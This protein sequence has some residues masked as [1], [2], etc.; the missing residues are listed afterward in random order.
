VIGGDKSIDPATF[1]RLSFP[2][3]EL[4]FLR[5]TKWDRVVPAVDRAFEQ[6]DAAKPQ[7]LVLD[8]RGNSGG[9]AT[10]MSPLAHL[11]REPVTVGSFL[12]RKWYDARRAAPSSPKPALPVLES[13]ASPS[14]LFAALRDHGGVTGKAMPRTPYF[15][16]TVF[17][18][19]DGGT[20]SAS[21]PLA[22]ALK[23]SRRATLVGEKTAGHMLTALPFGLRDGWVATIPVADFEAADG[24]RLEGTGVE[25]DVKAASNEAFLAVADRIGTRLPYSSAVLRGGSYETLERADDAERAYRAAVRVADKQTPAP[26]AAARATIHKRLANIRKAKGDVEGAL[27]EYREVLKLVPDDA[28]ANDFVKGKGRGEK[29]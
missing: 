19:V 1:V 15:A 23:T 21:E 24:V 5:I 25:P 26:S 16:G 8:I 12:S 29:G 9:D 7:V 3:P 17:L 20:A 14:Q 11:V 13:D 22:Y 4:A 2:A 27:R 28:E 18:L 6:I 10:S